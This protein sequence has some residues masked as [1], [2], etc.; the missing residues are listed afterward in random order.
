MPFIGFPITSQNAP[1]KKLRE[2]PLR[3]PSPCGKT[4]LTPC[5]QCTFCFLGCF[6][7]FLIC[8]LQISKS[9]PQNPR[10]KNQDS[11]IQTPK[12]RIQNQSLHQVLV[13][14]RSPQK[15]W[16]NIFLQIHGHSEQNIK[17]TKWNSPKKLQSS[18]HKRLFLENLEQ[19]PKMRWK[20]IAR[21]LFA[22][23][24]VGGG[25]TYHK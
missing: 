18:A 23:E 15:K 10:S 19:T 5:R 9:K 11:K 14:D 25:C 1:K 4:G 12:S 3:G 24:G 17:V 22:G 13:H 8:F 2:F 20:K 6:S 16:T 21:V 7:F